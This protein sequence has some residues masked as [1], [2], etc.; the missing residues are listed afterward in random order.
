MGGL[1]IDLIGD[2]HGMNAKLTKLRTVINEN[3]RTQL[4]S[5]DV[6][7]IGIGHTVSDVQAKQSHCIFAR[8]GCGKTLLLHHSRKELANDFRSIYVNCEDFKHH[9][10]PNVLIEIVDGVFGELESNLSAW[11]GRKAKLR[12]ILKELRVEL[13]SVKAKPDEYN[14]ER[15]E[16]KSVS[17]DRKN[18][19]GVKVGAS[20]IGTEFNASSELL[21][22]NKVDVE[23]K[24]SYNESKLQDLNHRLPKF[25]KLIKDFFEISG[26]IS[27]V[28]IQLDDFYQLNKS[29]QPFV[30]DYVHRLCKD[31]SLRFKIATLRHNSILYIERNGQPI[32]IQERHDYQPIDIDFTFES[33]E[34]TK[35]Q[36]RGIFLEYSKLAGMSEYEFD[37][38]FKGE[39][40]ERLI[41]A[42]GGVPRDSLSFFLEVLDRVRSN[43]ANGR[44]GKDDV[45]FL[46]RETFERRI[47]ELKQD[48]EGQDQNSL[49][50]GIHVIREFCVSVKK[51][52]I[53]LVSDKDIQADDEFKTLLFRLFDYRIIHRV[54]ASL[55]HKSKKS[56]GY[57]AFA[58]D[59]G[60]Y[61]F[62][63]NLQNKFNEID[64]TML[65]AKEKMRSAP[66]LE[67]MEFRKLWD[68][69]PKAESIEQALQEQEVVL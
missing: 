34:R 1:Y 41:L 55:T 12:T 18:N 44:I 20:K 62:M 17:N 56:S 68:A 54:S 48:S 46:S 52:N 10:F 59:V 67:A 49:L 57:Q 24:Y 58:I 11:F 7:Y 66:I 45:R 64:L 4:G 63:R 27:S 28:F 33:F 42:G 23:Q 21:S 5:R 60:C 38:L 3:L 39:G 36:N 31:T 65:D 53:F 37:S 9:S 61:A 51:S 40:F 19:L 30:A 14:L 69:T 35:N 2:I 6:S 29:D 8:R 22:S 43:D 26:K 16:Q 50:R 15:R 32:G 25:K 47:E 13:E